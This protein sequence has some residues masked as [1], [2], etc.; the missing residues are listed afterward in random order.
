MTFRNLLI[1]C[2]LLY[3]TPPI[4]AQN[5]AW[6]QKIDGQVDYLN[7]AVSPNGTE[8]LAIQF[9]DTISYAPDRDSTYSYGAL[10]SFTVCLLKL[11]EAQK[12]IESY[13]YSMTFDLFVRNMISTMKIDGN[14]N[15]YVSGGH[16]ELIFD[17][18][19]DTIVPFR[20]DENPYIMK[21][22]SNLHMIQSFTYGGSN[23]IDNI[24]DIEVNEKGT[25]TLGGLMTA[26]FN[27][28]LREDSVVRLPN[29]NS[30]SPFL[31]QYDQDFSLI[32]AHIFISR[33]RD[34][35]LALETDDNGSIYTLMSLT[36]SLLIIREA[37]SI[38][39]DP[40]T[41]PGWLVT[42]YDPAGQL[43]WYKSLLPSDRLDLLGFERD[44]MGILH[45]V[46]GTYADT[47]IFGD[48]LLSITV[49]PFRF[50]MELDQNGTLLRFN[51][52]NLVNIGG[53]RIGASKT[54]VLI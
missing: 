51:L 48:S 18:F 16:I 4:H 41:T 7:V 45:I 33:F 22:D 2:I 19:G 5:N 8:Y 37:D 31:A 24:S 38:W 47:L 23:N 15:L 21:L 28:D 46:G 10:D 14:G 54:A 13:R 12:P 26:F 25:I 39:L 20:I 11:D 53:A 35:H 6:V 17:E 44:E 52:F 3:I 1:V 42:H 36:D 50:W 34:R 9:R 29:P 40:G 30:G 49:D 32:H 43:V 27:Y